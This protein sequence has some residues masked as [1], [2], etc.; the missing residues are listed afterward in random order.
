MDF[1]LSE[2]QRHWRDRVRAFMDEHVRPAVP[3]YK[4]E[5]EAFGADRWQPVPVI[6]RLKPKA[7][8]A[9]LW[10]LFLPPSP[11]HDD[12]DFR[13]AGLTNLDYALC[14]EEMGRIQWA[15]EV[16]NCSAPDTGNM[17]VLH[18]YGTKA[19]K[20]RWLTPLMAGEIRSAFLMTEPDVASSDATNI[21]T[22]IRRDGDHY[23]I[24]GRKWWS[25][26]VGDPRCAVAIVMGKTDTSAPLHQQQSQILV[27][28]DTPGIE[29]VRML[30]VFGYDDAPHGHAE[31]I[32][33]DV[34]VPAENLLLG[35]GRG[36]E[37]AQ[38]R[39]GPGRIHHCMRTIGVAEEA[40]EKMAKRLL[41]RVAFGKRIAD[42]S[43]WEQR[44]GE[45]RTDIEMTRLLCLKAADMM[46][47]VGNKGAKLEIAMIKV[48]APRMALKIIDDAIQAHGGAGVSSDAG[49]AY[50]Y[51]RIRTLRLADGPDEVHNRSI[52]RL[53]LAQYGNR[54]RPKA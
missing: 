49:L 47:K 5:M 15:S 12:G 9:G 7:R 14:A 52:A 48:A 32:L 18:R 33:N 42:H 22:R 35:E 6:E 21:E 4:A 53:E 25:S 36:F 13:G 54:E 26:G 8:E 2:R 37:I 29:V 11:D 34:R 1:T 23:V 24:S 28:L 20:E 41:T 38:G 3:T 30:P 46:D 50:S 17:E 44:I 51:A 19:Q 16:F 40:L 43:V 45:A 39:L 31:V 27:P 10:N